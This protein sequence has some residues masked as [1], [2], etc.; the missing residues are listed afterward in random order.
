M[1]TTPE[2]ASNEPVRSFSHSHEGIVAR[3]KDMEKLPALL[4]PMAQARRIAA[5]S[6]KF[7]REVVFEHHSEEE[8]ELFPA[9]LASATKGEERAKVQQMVDQLVREHRDV[10]AAF[11]KLE[12]R[13]NA[14][15]KGQASEVDVAALDE[16]V[17]RYVAHA[18]F[19]EDTFLPLAETI[20]QRNANH[21]AALGVS[22]HA[23]HTMKD[24]KDHGGFHF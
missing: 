7:I 14:I 9:V 22:L 2:T 19:E 17:K 11:M 18:G 23:R 10:E 8:R 15:A 24:L 5:A 16:V 12:P 1:S 20:L 21:M 4:E 13:L 3:L 6:V